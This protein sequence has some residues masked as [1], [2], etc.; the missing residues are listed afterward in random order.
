MRTVVLVAISPAYAGGRG[1]WRWLLLLWFLLLPLERRPRKLCLLRL[2]DDSSSF[3]A[4]T[5]S[6]SLWAPLYTTLYFRPLRCSANDEEGM[7]LTL[8]QECGGFVCERSVLACKKIEKTMH[9][10]CLSRLQQ[11]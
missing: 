4:C 6:S 7:P 8:A 3:V 1:G 11:K 9:L 2:L 5:S 10:P